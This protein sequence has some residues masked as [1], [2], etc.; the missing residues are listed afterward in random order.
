MDVDYRADILSRWRQIASFV[1]IRREPQKRTQ[2]INRRIS[3][4]LRK[5][6]KKTTH[7]QRRSIRTAFI[8]SLTSVAVCILSVLLLLLLLCR[9]SLFL[10]LPFF[11]SVYKHRDCWHHLFFFFF[12]FSPVNI[13]LYAQRAIFLSF[14]LTAVNIDKVK[15]ISYRRRE[16]S[17]EAGR[18]WQTMKEPTTD[19]RGLILPYY[20]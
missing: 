5:E 17:A 18:D 10:I 6:A 1:L 20:F 13:F 11:C 9:C 14:S 4:T 7:A 16:N 2:R 3:C 19:S 8:T 12:L 15:R